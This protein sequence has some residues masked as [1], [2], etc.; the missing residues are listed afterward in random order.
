MPTGAVPLEPARDFHPWGL[1]LLV[2]HYTPYHSCLVD[3]SMLKFI[4]RCWSLA[5]LNTFHIW[6][7]LKNPFF[8]SFNCR[9]SDILEV[10]PGMLSLECLAETVWDSF[11][12]C[13]A[14]RKCGLCCRKMAGW[15]SVTRRYCVWKAKSIKT[16]STIW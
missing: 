14:M 2:S 3:K 12:P 6:E 9:F 15:M 11:Y 10:L 5:S 8:T 7:F 13:D 1:Y 16:F 4:Y